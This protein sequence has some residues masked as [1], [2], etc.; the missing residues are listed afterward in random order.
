MKAICGLVVETTEYSDNS[1]N[2]HI[3]RTLPEQ[4]SCAA[5][6]NSH[7]TNSDESDVGK[8]NQSDDDIGNDFDMN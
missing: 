4:M 8:Q 7:V 3:P 5:A 2:N 1:S 6:P